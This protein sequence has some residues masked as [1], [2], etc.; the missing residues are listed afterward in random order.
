MSERL[1]QVVVITGTLSGIGRAC[2][3]L[4]ACEGFQVLPV[5]EG[6]GINGKK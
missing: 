6:I 5:F 4:L 3:L 2:A 1:D